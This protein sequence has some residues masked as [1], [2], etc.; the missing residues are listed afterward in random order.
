M[1]TTRRMFREG[2]RSVAVQGC[3]GREGELLRPHEEEEKEKDGKE[4]DEKEEEEEQEGEQ[5][6]SSTIC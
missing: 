4:E 2:G 6:A 3:S 5:V 1:V